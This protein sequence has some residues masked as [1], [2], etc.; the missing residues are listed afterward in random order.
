VFFDGL[1][2]DKFFDTYATV[3]SAIAIARIKL[4]QFR[5]EILPSDAGRMYDNRDLK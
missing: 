2:K 1:T 4:C 5:D 3:D